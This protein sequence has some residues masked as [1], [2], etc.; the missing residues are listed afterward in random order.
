MED[1]ESFL[2]EVKL[3][4]IRTRE[5][6]YGRSIYPEKVVA[7]AFRLP[8]STNTNVQ[9]V[10]CLRAISLSRPFNRRKEF[11]LGIRSSQLT[12]HLRELVR[13]VVLP[14]IRKNGIG[15]NGISVISPKV[16][17]FVI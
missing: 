13:I 7:Y 15:N 1:G 10:L 6:A 11:L 9:S 14:P 4:T 5:S 16:R 17:C 3:A 12:K 2:E 8:P